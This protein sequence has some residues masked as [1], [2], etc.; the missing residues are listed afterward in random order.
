MKL[1]F[2]LALVAAISLTGAS[3]TGSDDG[4]GG[5]CDCRPCEHIQ[6]DD[7]CNPCPLA[8]HHDYDCGDYPCDTDECTTTTVA[9]TTTTVPPTTTTMPATTTTTV[10]SPPVFVVQAPAATPIHR[11]PTVTG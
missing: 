8:P 6:E 1:R 3:T 10:V 2:L 4:S 11:V 5:G 9:P 7:W